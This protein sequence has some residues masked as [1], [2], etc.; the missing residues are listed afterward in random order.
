MVTSGLEYHLGCFIKQNIFFLTTPAGTDP[1]TILQRKF[2]ATL[3]FQ[4]FWL[5][6]AIFQPIRMLKNSVA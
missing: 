2:Y 6:A 5:A 4:A 3:F 1:I